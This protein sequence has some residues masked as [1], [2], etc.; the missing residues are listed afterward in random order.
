[1][2]NGHLCLQPL[3]SLLHDLSF[4][5]VNAR[6]GYNGIVFQEISPASSSLNS[7]DEL[8]KL[9]YDVRTSPELSSFTK[10]Q[11]PMTNTAACGIA[12]QFIPPRI[13][14][15]VRRRTAEKHSCASSEFGSLRPQ[16]NFICRSP[17]TI[18]LGLQVPS[19]K[20]FRVGQEVPNIF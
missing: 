8:V 1:M 3:A 18:S 13:P 16:R 10:D 7:L 19:K 15:S 12:P 9:N 5:M 2:T 11:T 4:K 17:K 20:V 14:R 6:I